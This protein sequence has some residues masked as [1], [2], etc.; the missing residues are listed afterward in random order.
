MSEHLEVRKQLKWFL[1]NLDFLIEDHELEEKGIAVDLYFDTFD[2]KEA[3][4]GL[5][6]FYYAGAFNVQKIET[7]F[8]TQEG[9][10]LKD[11]MLVLCLAFSE[12]LGK[13]NMLP[14]HQ[15]EFLEG[16]NKGFNIDNN[17]PPSQMVH[18]FL[19]AV[20]QTAVIKREIASLSE[21]SALKD[22][23]GEQAIQHVR[24]HA[25]EHAASA[26]NFYKIVQ[27]IRGIGWK[28]R[29]L[30]MS[31]GA[32]N[33]IP[34]DIDYD[35]IIRSHEFTKFY[36]SFK[37]RRRER[38]RERQ[39]PG[40]FADA[41]ALTM[42][43]NRVREVNEYE[44]G[45]IPRFFVS[46]KHV[47]LTPMFVSVLEDAGLETSLQYNI[48]YGQGER[49]RSTVIRGSDYFVFKSTFQP[50]SSAVNPEDN[51][52][53]T[54]PEELYE[55]R[56]KISKILDPT[57]SESASLLTPESL[58]EIVISGKGL[59]QI[60]EDL[61][62]LLFFKNV[63]LP[64]SK[65]DVELV[66]EDLNRAADE[67]KSE[68]LEQ[69]VNERIQEFKVSIV[70]NAREYENIKLIWL[71]MEDAAKFLE[72][73]WEERIPF[74]ADYLRDFGLLRFSFPESA[75]QRIQEVLD[76]LLNGT[77]ED[78]RLVY[79]NIVT[80]C[81]L[82]Q[83]E[84]PIRPVDDNDLV[85]AATV[86]WVAQ[87]YEQLA[88]L[89]SKVDSLPHY[90]LEL[91]YTAALIEKAQDDEM[92]LK[93]MDRLEERHQKTENAKEK[94]DLAVGLA[95][96]KYHLWKKL[97][98]GSVWDRTGNQYKN[99][100]QGTALI[101]S[102]IQLAFEAWMSIGEW[103]KKKEIYALNQY[104]YYLVMEG[105]ES[106]TQAI[107]SAAGA[108]LGKRRLNI[109]ELWQHR[110]DDSLAHYHHWLALMDI[111]EDA[112]KA[113]MDTAEY[114]SKEASSKAPWD[115]ETI[116]NLHILQNQ[117]KQGFKKSQ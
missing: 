34:H 115:K 64:S 66:L 57:S 117:L 65:Q 63:W 24:E 1:R 72:K 15:S 6:S 32:L 98:Y 99:D 21:I 38:E 20:S 56:E 82:A 19:Q 89:L 106:N 110:F 93:L 101:N 116:T 25:G 35:E 74:Q 28:E 62:T 67:L 73:R 109:R 47:G 70:E 114:Y 68:V 10:P 88:D 60:I 43:V 30:S 12:R 16:L 46:S 111:T 18:Q 58:D 59:K 37:G 71:R 17:L 54:D 80:A 55:L 95:Y 13:I 87:M 91:I 5:Q 104:L 108:L 9:R 14:P 69:N 40:N 42:L 90:S 27:L 76:D 48:P 22:G 94:A 103:D 77:T 79:R 107:N 61:N 31:K 102:A 45:P 11:R 41:V 84:S 105:D 3:V 83:L 50:P 96:L 78:E 4:L 2:V 75:N 52:E 49:R 23:S 97:G 100:A 44:Q 86:L 8:Q 7:A 92:V 112:W 113:N 29:L 39:W 85:A 36:K 51:V 26:M 53:F 81:Y 33:L